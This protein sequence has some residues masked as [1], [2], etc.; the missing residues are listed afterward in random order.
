[1]EG[2]SIAPLSD[3][4]IATLRSGFSHTKEDFLGWLEDASENYSNEELQAAL[5]WMDAQPAEGFHDALHKKCVVEFELAVDESYTELLTTSTIDTTEFPLTTDDGRSYRVETT[6]LTVQFTYEHT[7]EVK[8][9]EFDAATDGIDLYE[10]LVQ[11][12][13]A[14]SE[15]YGGWSSH[16]MMFCPNQY[17]TRVYVWRGPTTALIAQ[18]IQYVYA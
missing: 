7:D 5:L 2:K 15:G 17:N 3:F 9:H 16:E 6:H 13:E 4:H 8:V 1:M 18:T 14:A 10:L 11:F 12:N